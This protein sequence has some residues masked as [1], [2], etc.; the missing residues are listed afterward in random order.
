MRE[1]HVVPLS[2]QALAILR[3]LHAVTGG[4]R[5]AFPSI[6]RPSECLS[7]GTLNAA[8]RRLDYRADEIGT[9]GFRAMASTILNESGLWREDVIEAQLA[10]KRPGGTVRAAYNRAR[11]LP[12][13]RKMMQWW[14]DHLDTLRSGKAG[15]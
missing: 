12:E 15:D 14:A 6:H 2:R 3:E 4:G 11:Y 1:D 13:R 10:H 5:L 7:D 9:H 8:L